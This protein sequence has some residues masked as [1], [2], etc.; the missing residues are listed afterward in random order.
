[1]WPT[2]TWCCAALVVD[3]PPASEGRGRAGRLVASAANNV[4]APTPLPRGSLVALVTPMHPDGALDLR[5]LR[6]LLQLHVA[7]GTDGVVALGTTGESSVLSM[8]ERAEVLAV[9]RDELEGRVPLIVGT[10]GIDPK[11]V[12]AMQEQALEFGAAA[13]L[14]VTPYYTKPT[15]P[16]LTRF[17]T[18]VADATALPVV[19]Y[20]VPGRTCCDLRPE[21]VAELSS[22]PR[23]GGIKEVCMRSFTQSFAEMNETI[24]RARVRRAGDG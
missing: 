4:G 7:S 23:I 22:H 17:F 16:G 3:L 20:N 24:R 12:I 13:G 1:M 9:C 2:L 10:G 19:L 18:A 6:G 15:Q 8:D 21:T 11:K 5:S 14:V